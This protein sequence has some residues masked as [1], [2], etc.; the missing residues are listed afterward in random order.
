MA[1]AQDGVPCYRHVLLQ[2]GDVVTVQRKEFAYTLVQL[3]DGQEGYV[4]ND[5]LVPSPSTAGGSSDSSESAHVRKVAKVR[6]HSSS[7]ARGATP[8]DVP[9]IPSFRY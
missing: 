8:S 2:K 9:P 1:V 5:D 7:T 6:K 3:R 4:A